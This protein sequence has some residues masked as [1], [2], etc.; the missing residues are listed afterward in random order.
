MVWYI[1]SMVI[2]DHGAIRGFRYCRLEPA[3]ALGSHRAPFT[4]KKQTVPFF[5]RGQPEFFGAHRCSSSPTGNNVLAICSATYRLRKVVLILFGSSPLSRLG[6]LHQS[7]RR[8][9]MHA[10]LR[11]ALEHQGV[12]EEGFKPDLAVTQGCPLGCA[13]S[14]V[15]GKQCAKHYC[16]ST[17]RQISG[18]QCDTDL[19]SHT[20]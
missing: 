6:T 16:P 11:S 4:D 10:A 13:P 2:A 7:R 14:L 18:L 17:R 3:D 1:S 15:F 8:T 9:V 19:V 20:A 12:V 5:R